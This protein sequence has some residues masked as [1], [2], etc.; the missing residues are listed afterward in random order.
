MKAK[1]PSTGKTPTQD[2]LSPSSSLR[3][4][5][6]AQARG[7]FAQASFLRLGESSTH[8]TTAST[9]CRLGEAPLA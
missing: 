1:H 9:H 2:A 8:R 5:G 7:S 4:K 3:L 6:L